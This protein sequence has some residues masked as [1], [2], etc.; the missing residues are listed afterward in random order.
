MNNSAQENVW[1]NDFGQNYTDR[2]N[3]MPD[4]L[5]KMYLKTIGVKRSVINNEFLKNISK[6]ARILEIGCNMGNQL[7]MLKSQGFKNLYGIEIMPYAVEKAKN[8][9]EGINIIQGSAFDIPFKD[10]YFDLVF[11]SGVLIHIKPEDLKEVMSEIIRCSRKYIWGYEYFSEEF[12]NVKY[13]GNDELL[14]K[15]NYAEEYIKNYNN[16]KIVSKKMFSLLGT[17]NRD[18]MFL[19]KKEG[20]N[21]IL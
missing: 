10:N 13:R 20:Q 21:E 5:D 19:L 6:D 14:W 9:T 2:N 11:T 4:E 16:M 8:R 3:Y 1:K 7:I 12:A 15:G 18:Q 17:E